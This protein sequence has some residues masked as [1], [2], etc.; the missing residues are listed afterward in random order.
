MALGTTQNGDTAR[1]KTDRRQ[2]ES[3]ARQAL[4]QRK[5]CAM[6]PALIDLGLKAHQVLITSS[7]LNTSTALD[8]PEQR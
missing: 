5:N 1:P 3:V 8:S 2:E 4:K 6:I 7:S